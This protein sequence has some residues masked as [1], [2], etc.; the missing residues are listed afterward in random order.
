MIKA[1]FWDND[2]I[3]VDTEKL[4]FEA[5]QITFRKI[6]IEL[7]REL[8]IENFLIKAKGTWHLAREKG[9]SEN[10]IIKFRAERNDLYTNLIKNE[11]E[12]IKGVEDVLKMLH[13]KIKMG[14]V[15][16]SRN[17]HFQLIH[18]STGLTKYFDFVITSDDIENTKPD[19]EAYLKALELSGYPPE[20]CMVIE[21]S[22]RGLKAAIAAGLRCCVI[23]TELTF[24][25]NFTGA[26]KV[27][28]SITD[29]LN[30]P[31]IQ[32]LL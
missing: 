15:T 14:I 27:L 20:E 3:L 2:G 29:L 5:N 31:E 4:Y 21:D 28:K 17:D 30:L 22:E 18:S 10:E 13:G 24:G 12:V 1:I 25:G 8:F 7:T 23:P 26:Y 32:I 11:A 9:I 16:S 6:G 19:P